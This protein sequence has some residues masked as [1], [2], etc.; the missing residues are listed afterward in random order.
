[1]PVEVDVL[2]QHGR[3]LPYDHPVHVCTDSSTKL[4]FL[5]DKFFIPF[6]VDNKIISLGDILILFGILSAVIQIYIF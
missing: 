4:R 6:F 1:M 2:E 5:D 3:K